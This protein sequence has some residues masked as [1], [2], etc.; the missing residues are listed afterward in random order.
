MHVRTQE[1]ITM[2]ECFRAILPL[3]PSVYP[4]VRL[5]CLSTVLISVQ[6]ERLPVH[7][8]RHARMHA[9]MQLLMLP[10]LQIGLTRCMQARIPTRPRATKCMYMC[11]SGSPRT[12]SLHVVVYITLRSTRWVGIKAGQ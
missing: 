9:C 4:L 12:M 3:K 6:F 5:I 11:P 1:H 10:D 7:V 8:W 2:H